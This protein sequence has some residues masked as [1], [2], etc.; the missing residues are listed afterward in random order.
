[1]SQIDITPGVEFQLV[2]DKRCG[3]DRSAHLKLSLIG[4]PAGSIK[5]LPGFDRPLGFQR[6]SLLSNGERIIRFAHDCKALRLHD[7]VDFHPLT[8]NS[9]NDGFNLDGTIDFG[10]PEFPTSVNYKLMFAKQSRGKGL[11]LD[12]LPSNLQFENV[13]TFKSLMERKDVQI[14]EDGKVELHGTIEEQGALAPIRV[15]VWKKRTSPG[16][17]RIWMDLE[18]RDKPK[19]SICLGGGSPGSGD[20]EFRIEKADMV[21]SNSFRQEPM[22]IRADSA[23]R[24][25]TSY[26]PVI[27][28]RIRR[29]TPKSSRSKWW[30]PIVIRSKKVFRKTDLW[31]SCC[32]MTIR[33]GNWW[34]I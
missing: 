12:V 28:E 17:Y 1:M 19:Q 15:V 10:I 16:N 34:A 23:R 30:V 3:S 32:D 25:S 21:V 6:I 31:I 5:N 22:A 2:A 24:L 33:I 13:G 7:V 14:I 20:A 27:C 11:K 9:Y 4:D 26:W 18:D 8:I 29:L